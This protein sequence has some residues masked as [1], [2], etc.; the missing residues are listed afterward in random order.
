MSMENVIEVKPAFGV[1]PHCGSENMA[2]VLR[3]VNG[4]ESSST[5]CAECGGRADGN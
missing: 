5:E 1:C 3:E 4:T 2:K